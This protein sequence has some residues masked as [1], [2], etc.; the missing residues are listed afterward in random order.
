M[1]LLLYPPLKPN[2]KCVPFSCGYNLKSSCLCLEADINYLM[3]MALD[4]IA[5]LPFGFL[6]DQWRW[7]VFRGDTT[8]DQYNR[9]W[10]DLR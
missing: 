3:S 4:K 6:M 10:W 1:T 8:K 9:K 7:S 2:M 5:F